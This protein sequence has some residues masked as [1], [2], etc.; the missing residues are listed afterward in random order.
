MK[1]AKYNNRYGDDIIFT[2]LSETEIEMSGFEYYRWGEDFIDPSGGPFIRIGTDVG[3]YFDDDKLRKVKAINV[4][5]NKII[6]TI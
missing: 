1:Q 3:R 2:E 4:K 6:L 5:N